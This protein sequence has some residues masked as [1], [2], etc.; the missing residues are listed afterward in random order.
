MSAGD[1]GTIYDPSLQAWVLDPNFV[2]TKAHIA[3][4][5]YVYVSDVAIILTDAG[6]V[7]QLVDRAE[8]MVDRIHMWL[9][10]PI[11][12]QLI[13][14]WYAIRLNKITVKLETMLPDDGDDA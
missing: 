9:E 2:P 3:V 5:D 6:T 10:I 11:I 1:P 8:V 12:G 14:N 7:D 4:S 13:A